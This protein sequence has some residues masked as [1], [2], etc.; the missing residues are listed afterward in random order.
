MNSSVSAPERR[1]HRPR[2]PATPLHASA[3][4]VVPVVL[5]V[6]SGG[7]AMFIDH[8]QGSTLPSAALLGLVAAVVVGV[9]CYVAG[10]VQGRVLPE[11]RAGLYGT[12]LG[13]VIGFLYCL[14]GAAVGRASGVGLGVALAMAAVTFY[15]IHARSD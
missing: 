10:R 4:W 8:N 15:V 12:L 5:G 9:A 11:V 7:Y 2:L 13:C 3:S 1:R 14:S 6:L